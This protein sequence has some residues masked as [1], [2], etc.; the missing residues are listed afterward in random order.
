M[1]VLDTNVVSELFRPQPHAGVVTWL[2]ERTGDVA[3]TAVTASELLAG[4]RRLPDG[5][6]RAGL[7]KAVGAVL[8]EHHERGLILPFDSSAADHYADIFVTREQMGRPIH[9]ADAQ[10]AAVCRSIGATCATRNVEDFASVGVDVI[11]PWRD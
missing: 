10:I 2:E 11:D 6:R 3:I 7:A 9:T 1:I 5:K 8:N 4:V